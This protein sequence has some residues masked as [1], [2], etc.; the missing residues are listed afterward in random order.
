MNMGIPNETPLH[1]DT[2]P[3]FYWVNPNY[4]P[5]CV[6]HHEIGIVAS[7]V[8]HQWKR[9]PQSV[10]NPAGYGTSNVKVILVSMGVVLPKLLAIL[11]THSY[12]QPASINQLGIGVMWKNQ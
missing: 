2:S 10:H 6:V 11:I 7:K 3:S 5:I 4:L 1:H 9:Q 8:Q 12:Y